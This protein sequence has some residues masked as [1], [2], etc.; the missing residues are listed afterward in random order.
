MGCD[1]YFKLSVLVV[2][3]NYYAC[4]TWEHRNDASG[5]VKGEFFD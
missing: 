3:Y 1:F 5:C 4:I 2:K